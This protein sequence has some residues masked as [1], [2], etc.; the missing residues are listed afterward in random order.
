V[1][2]FA[3]SAG[4]QLQKMFLKSSSCTDC[5]CWNPSVPSQYLTFLLCYEKCL[6]SFGFPDVMLEDSDMSWNAL[7]VFFGAGVNMLKKLLHSHDYLWEVQTG[8]S[9]AGGMLLFGE[10]LFT[11]CKEEYLW[12]H[13]WHRSIWVANTSSRGFDIFCWQWVRDWKSPQRECLT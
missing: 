8:R 5:M 7:V 6:C 11:I 13:T 9:I 4:L 1:K 10:I 12:I 3:S 2:L